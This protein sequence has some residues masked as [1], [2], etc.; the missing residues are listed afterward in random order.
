MERVVNIYGSGKTKIYPYS[1]IEKSGIINDSHEEKPVV[2]FYSKG[3]V[4]ILDTK[5]ISEAKKIGSVAVYDPILNGQHLQFE[6]SRKGFKDN[7]TGSVW[8]MSGK[9][10]EGFFKGKSLTP[11]VH[12]N[13]FAFA[14]LSF[15][16]YTEIYSE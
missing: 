16:P 6:K 1:I 12:G 4:S 7:I 11:V 3:A 9:C 13:H 15:Y 10:V 2:I 14:W 5:E 8:N